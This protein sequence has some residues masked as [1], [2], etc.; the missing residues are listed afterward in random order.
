MSNHNY[1]VRSQSADVLPGTE[2]SYRL[3]CPFCT[4]E[5]N[6]SVNGLATYQSKCTHLFSLSSLSILEGKLLVEFRKPK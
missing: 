2:H 4:L 6:M 1:E 3:H 5:I